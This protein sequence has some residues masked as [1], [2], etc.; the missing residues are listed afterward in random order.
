M[1]RVLSA[2]QLSSCRE[3]A[4]ISGVWTFL[5]AED[6]GPKQGLSQK[7]CPFYLSQKLC[8]FGSLHSHL[9]RLVSEESRIQDCSLTCFCRALP[10]GH[11][12][13]GG[14]GAL[15]S[16]AEMG[17]VPEAVL[18]LPIPEAMSFL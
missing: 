15:M 5:L 11:L 7:L 2:G 16:G 14:E 6:E 9:C 12:S 13:S 18:L 1:V 10:G 8:S 4:Q 3:G 17:S